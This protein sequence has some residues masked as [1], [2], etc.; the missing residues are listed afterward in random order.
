MSLDT[1]DP[2]TRFPKPFASCMCLVTAP[3]GKV[4]TFCLFEGKL[5]FSCL[6]AVIL[7]LFRSLYRS[8]RVVNASAMVPKPSVLPLHQDSA[9]IGELGGF[10]VVLTSSAVFAVVITS[11]QPIC[12]C[13]H[14]HDAFVS[15]PGLWL[16]HSSG[17]FLAHLCSSV[18]LA[19]KFGITDVSVGVLKPFTSLCTYLNTFSVFAWLSSPPGTTLCSL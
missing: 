1:V 17:L 11:I 18:P 10:R 16:R 2:S 7:M 3:I 14:V 12:A 6:L 5:I 4:C 15:F 19:G 8:M 9:L 13:I